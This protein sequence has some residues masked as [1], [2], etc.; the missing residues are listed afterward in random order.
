MVSAPL[1]E[2]L[3]IE[4]ELASAVAESIDHDAGGSAEIDLG[5]DRQGG[6]VR[7]E[8]LVALDAEVGEGEK[9]AD[10]RDRAVGRAIR[11]SLRGINVVFRTIW[12]RLRIR[13]EP[14]RKDICPLWL[15]IKHR[16]EVAKLAQRL[17]ILRSL[18]RDQIVEIEATLQVFDE[19]FHLAALDRNRR[20]RC[21][22]ALGGIVLFGAVV[23][24]LLE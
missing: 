24:V 3:L 7:S 1:G 15:Q 13:I 14:V 2:T 11:R 16:E 9:L 8:L 21:G 5:S 6:D 22:P 23:E 4:T 17:L 12:S 19:P 10:T 20:N 18:G